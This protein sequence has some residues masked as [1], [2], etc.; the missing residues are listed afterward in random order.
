M[1]LVISGIHPKTNLLA[2]WYHLYFAKQ[3]E[4]GLEQRAR[5]ID[6]FEGRVGESFYHLVLNPYQLMLSHREKKR[7]LYVLAPTPSCQ[8]CFGLSLFPPDTKREGRRRNTYRC[9][10]NAKQLRNSRT[11]R[12]IVHFFLSHYT[13][14]KKMPYA[15]SVIV[16]LYSKIPNVCQL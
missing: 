3:T 15:L 16:G 9:C 6:I 2:F 4:K 13:K 11:R 7:I 14:A 1:P 8:N 5:E 12:K 10:I